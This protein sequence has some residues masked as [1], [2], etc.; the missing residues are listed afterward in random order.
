M[1]I[2]EPPHVSHPING[3]FVPLATLPTFSTP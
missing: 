2:T 1:K 3:R